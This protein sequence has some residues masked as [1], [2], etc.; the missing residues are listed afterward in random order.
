MHGFVRRKHPATVA[1]QGLCAALLLVA[2]IT[3]GCGPG[4]KTTPPPTLAESIRDFREMA[5]SEYGRMLAAPAGAAAS[6][7]A[8]KEA[9]EARSREYGEPFTGYLEVANEVETSWASKPSAAA[10]KQ[11]VGVLREAL[12]RMA[13]AEKR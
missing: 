5:E 10:V 11:G 8:I 3:A 7:T 4:V 6:L 1:V 2:A 12:A 9:I 13:D